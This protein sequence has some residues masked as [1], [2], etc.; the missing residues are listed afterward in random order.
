M[1][2]VISLPTLSAYFKRM[3]LCWSRATLIFGNSPIFPRQQNS[4]A[5]LF[6]HKRSLLWTVLFQ[7]FYGFK[8]TGAF[9]LSELTGQSI[10]VKMRISLLIKTVQSDQSDPK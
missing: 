4:R 1:N 2:I 6:S 10:P 9:H 7:P 5:S 8:T 3:L